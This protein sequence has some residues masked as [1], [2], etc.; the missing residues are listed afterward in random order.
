VLLLAR[1]GFTVYS[2]K[3]PQMLPYFSSLGHECPANVNPADFALDLVTV[4]LQ[5][6][7]RE[8]ETRVKVQSLISQFSHAEALAEDGHEREKTVS[9]PAE[10]GQMKRDMAP[11]HVAYPI[12]LRRSLLNIKRQPPL[13]TARIMQVLGL[14]FIHA[15]FFAPLKNNYFAVQNRMGFVQQFTSLYFVGLLQNVAICRTLPVACLMGRMLTLLDPHER[16]VFYKEHDDRAYSTTSFFL[17]YTTCEIPFEII[18][19]LLFAILANLAVGLPRTAELFFI[20]AAEVFFITN[21]GESLGII[22]NTLFQHTG[23]SINITSSVLS[24]GV[25]MSGIMSTHMPPVLEGI[26]YIS[27]LKYAVQCLVPASLKGVKFTCADWQRLPGGRCPVEDG[28]DVMK[29]YGMT[30]YTPWKNL[31]AL[32]AVAVLYR[33]VAYAVVVA[34]RARWGVGGRKE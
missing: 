13:I 26:N 31:V 15:L 5:H 14:G 3:A 21:S 1:G 25:I 24:I 6:Q 4:D 12:L 34:K 18:T 10:L 30:G 29:L 9:L 11:F 23:F 20:V 33:L 7:D 27:P 8:T 16:D 28:E 32:A 19:C 17:A 2:G 22:F